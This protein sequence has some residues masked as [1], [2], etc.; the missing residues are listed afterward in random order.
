M[1]NSKILKGF[2]HLSKL[3]KKFPTKSLNAIIGEGMRN[4]LLEG[5]EWFL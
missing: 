1:I 4:P 3:D 2:L 5:L